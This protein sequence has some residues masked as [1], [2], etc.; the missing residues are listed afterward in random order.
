[1]ATETKALHATSV[2]F[3]FV[4]DKTGEVVEG[5]IDKPFH[6]NGLEMIAHREAGRVVVQNNENLTDV[7][8]KPRFRRLEDDEDG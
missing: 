2:S 8:L 4:N 7:A 1:M 6:L 5:T 3:R